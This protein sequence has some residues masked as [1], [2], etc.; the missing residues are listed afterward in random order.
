VTSYISCK[1]IYRTIIINNNDDDND[2][3]DDDDNNNNN[4]STTD[5]YHSTE[6]LTDTS[7][8]QH[9][10]YATYNKGHAANTY[11]IYLYFLFKMVL[12][13]GMFY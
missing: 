6:V 11:M 9:H 10:D 2:D 12:N 8:T 7:I 3:D 5:Q 13:K 1:L 4:N